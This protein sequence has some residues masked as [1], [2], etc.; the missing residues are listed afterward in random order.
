[1]QNGKY[2]MF[3]YCLTGIITAGVSIHISGV[4]MVL[5]STAAFDTPFLRQ[6]I[7]HP[8]SVL[9]PLIGPE[10]QN[11]LIFLCPSCLFERRLCAAVSSVQS[12]TRDS[13]DI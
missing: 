4:I 3:G 7:R 1:M 9:S 11:G 5:S 10:L 6:A 13:M 12:R 2:K 8:R